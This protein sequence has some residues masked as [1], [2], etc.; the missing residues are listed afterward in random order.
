MASAPSE[1]VWAANVED[2]T[3]TL[4]L[5]PH[6]CILAVLSRID[7]LG[8]PP[9]QAS[10]LARVAMSCSLFNSLAEEAAD[11]LLQR[12]LRD[13]RSDLAVESAAYRYHK[14]ASATSIR[15]LWG[16]VPML[17]L[18]W[19]LLRNSVTDVLENREHA[20]LPALQ[21]LGLNSIIVKGCIRLSWPLPP[22]GEQT[23]DDYVCAL[24]LRVARSQPSWPCHW[25]DIVCALG[26]EVHP[27]LLTCWRVANR[28]AAI[29]PSCHRWRKFSHEEHSCWTPDATDIELCPLPEALEKRHAEHVARLRTG[30]SAGRDAEEFD[31]TEL[32]DM[33]DAIERSSA[34]KCTCEGGGDLCRYI[35][36]PPA[37]AQPR[38][39][40]STP[41]DDAVFVALLDAL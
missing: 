39:L 38:A 35:G 30:H 18:Q 6:D 10:A 34:I 27:G 20:L 36:V 17:P 21:N 41:V 14:S 37:R 28:R 5:L 3:T 23:D 2:A 12:Y 16:G 32:C 26:L 33:N 1:A 9:E 4:T 19:T 40:P 7:V 29:C 11:C 15:T 31:A 13:I 8:S 24:R 22:P 25:H